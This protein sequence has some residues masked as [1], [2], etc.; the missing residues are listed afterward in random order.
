MTSVTATIPRGG[1]DVKV[2]HSGRVI[3]VIMI[4][5]RMKDVDEG[6]EAWLTDCKQGVRRSL[7]LVSGYD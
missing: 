3:I 6:K 7:P 1:R 4:D 5:A 2:S